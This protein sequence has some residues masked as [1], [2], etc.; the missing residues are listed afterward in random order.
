MDSFYGGHQGTSFV[1]KASFPSVSDMQKKFR[2]GTAYK[3]VWFGEYCI[4]NTP[5]KNNPDNGKIF[6]RGAEYAKLSDI[7]VDGDNRRG[8]PIEI[9][10][11]VGPSGGIPFVEF[12]TIQDIVDKP[13]EETGLHGYAYPNRTLAGDQ[14]KTDECSDD[15]I[16]A[17]QRLYPTENGAYYD[18]NNG[19][20]DPDPITL[21]L[22]AKRNGDGTIDTT[23]T[24]SQFVSGE[25]MDHIE[26]TWCDVRMNDES[27]PNDVSR[28]YIGFKVPYHFFTV[29]SEQVSPYVQNDTKNAYPYAETATANI[30]FNKI[31]H[32]DD[33]VDNPF[34]HNIDL[35]IPT[36][37][38]GIAY[39]DFTIVTFDDTNAPSDNSK[40]KVQ[41][42][43][44]DDIEIVP[45]GHRPYAKIKENP[46]PYTAV[47]GDRALVAC[48]RC[49][50]DYA[51]PEPIYDI[52]K[53]DTDPSTSSYLCFD[54]REGHKKTN[55]GKYGI[56]DETK[57]VRAVWVYLSEYD[58]PRAGTK[59]MEYSIDDPAHPYNENVTNKLGSLTTDGTLVLYER[60]GAN[61][62]KASMSSW[63]GSSDAKPVTFGS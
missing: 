35:K 58:Q 1:I 50:D 22:E 38:P 48:L 5:D 42:Y 7:D 24:D 36:G 32:G 15:T 30:T 47:L 49:Y 63:W 55:G 14:W 40:P 53:V 45:N 25:V 37:I 4:I 54:V 61:N 29:T 31:Q 8:D 28:L 39:T 57:K 2:Q 20:G 51:D 60:M 59:F 52:R 56:D 34:N 9:A 21:L 26:W 46:N 12:T 11:I 13:N 23:D 10:Q 19:G 17:E 33:D 41:L 43:R 6:R 3:D 16:S 44:S 18:N 27:Y 62:I